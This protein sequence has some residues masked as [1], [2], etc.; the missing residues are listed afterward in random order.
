MKALSSCKTQKKKHKSKRKW[1]KR[2]ICKN[3][4]K[5]FTS[6]SLDKI[7]LVFSEMSGNCFWNNYYSAFQW[8][9]NYLNFWN[10]SKE[11]QTLPSSSRNKTLRTK[12]RKKKKRI[13][14]KFS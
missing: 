4:T 6:F 7:Q 9:N 12:D 1:K 8:R 11:V 13:V 5:K 10:A 3:L 14:S 2:K